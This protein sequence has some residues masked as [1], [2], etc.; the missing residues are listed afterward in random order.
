MAG[1]KLDR[2]IL[3]VAPIGFDTNYSYKVTSSGLLDKRPVM[4]WLIGT[5]PTSGAYLPQLAES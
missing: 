2:L 5:D 4:E 1:G 3:A